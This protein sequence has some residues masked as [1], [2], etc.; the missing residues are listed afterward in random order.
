MKI[1]SELAGLELTCPVW[2]QLVKSLPT[3]HHQHRDAVLSLPSLT[4]APDW[5]HS[6]TCPD[7]GVQVWESS[8]V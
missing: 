7:L 3:T 4:P 6:P 1:A 5:H 2:S 8:S